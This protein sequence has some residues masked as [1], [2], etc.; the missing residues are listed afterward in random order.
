MNSTA[1]LP[2]TGEHHR[3]I[4]LLTLTIMVGFVDFLAF[5]YNANIIAG[6]FFSPYLS[7]DISQLYAIIVF[8]AGY[9]S[10]PLGA[11]I[12]G[13]YGDKYGR[14]RVLVASLLAV[15]LCTL[16]IALLPTYQDIG[17]LAT[18]LF[19]LARFGQGMAFGSHL[20][21]T[22]V[23]AS[24]KLPLHSIGFAGGMICAGSLFG[25]ILLIAMLALL[26]G[27]LTQT[28]MTNYGW[29]MPFLFGGVAGLCLLYFLKNKLEST[30]F[31]KHKT[32]TEN[33]NTPPTKTP[34]K[35]RW[36]GL[37]GVVALSWFLASLTT[38]VLF[39]LNDLIR[40]TFFVPET[41]LDIGF[42]VCLVFLAAGCVFFGFLADRANAGKVL[43]VGMIFFIIATVMLF[44]ALEHQGSLILFN[45]ALF[46]LS[47]GVIGAIPSIL[48]RLCPIKHRL[49]TIAI[50][51]NSVY[52][53]V[54]IFTP[55]LLGFFTYH[56]SYAPMLY[57]SLLALL[58]LFLS[59]YIYY[60]PKERVHQ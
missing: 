24:E 3:L 12:V 1:S 31:V 44:F 52:A 14:K 47:G 21:S 50:G 13:H 30:V 9:L 2:L 51:Y 18:M 6:Q 48:V 38:I 4:I 25:A 7:P 19:V 58:M 28:Q 26:E 53:L 42:V 15:S 37:F 39:V 32:A 33:E 45:F 35:T 54:G 23:Y 8:V 29:R 40:L 36:R 41:I 56:A 43:A 17:I 49:S 10:R 11:V 55:W 5:W 34:L 46:G 20:P 57:L 22:W 16:L 60:V 27:A 59:F